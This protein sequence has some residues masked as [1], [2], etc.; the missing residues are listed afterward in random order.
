MR[1]MRAFHSVLLYK[2]SALCL[3]EAFGARRRDSPHPVAAG[4]GQHFEPDARDRCQL[5]WRSL[6]AA[7]PARA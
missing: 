2:I 6:K 1:S 7:I 4:I 5:G 3:L